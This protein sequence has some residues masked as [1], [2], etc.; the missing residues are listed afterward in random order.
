[1]QMIDA[2]LFTPITNLTTNKGSIMKELRELI[3]MMTEQIE[4]FTFKSASD[5]GDLLR[6][7]STLKFVGI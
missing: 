2:I 7:F 4:S 1:M 3:D 5:C 6:L